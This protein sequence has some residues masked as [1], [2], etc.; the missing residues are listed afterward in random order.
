MNGCIDLISQELGYP[1]MAFNNTYG[2]QAINGSQYKDAIDNFHRP[3]TGCLAL[4]LKCQALAD[5]FDPGAYGHDEEVNAAC[6]EASDYC[7]FEVESQ[8]DASER[9]LF[10]IA[11]SWTSAYTPPYY[12]GF[13]AQPWVQAA[14]GV[15]VNFTQQA[16]A[17]AE[18]YNWTGV[19]ARRDRRRG[20]IGDIGELLDKG[21]KVALLYGDRDYSCNCKS[22]D[23]SDNISLGEVK[24]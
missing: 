19:Y 14:L 15:P 12:L 24:S 21:V 9:N 5:K 7:I 10:D 13:L 17:T 16:Q 18:A 2:I 11:A 8:Y 6:A 4:V 1:E 20:P 23:P 22:A 3:Q